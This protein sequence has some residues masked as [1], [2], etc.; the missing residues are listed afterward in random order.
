MILAGD[1]GGTSTRLALFERRA[2][3]LQILAE[4]TYPSQQYPG[5]E[6]IAR[7]FTAEHQARVTKACF[8]IPG[9]VRNGRV[10]TPN[11][12][13][14]VDARV[15]SGMLKTGAVRLINDLE[16]NAHGIAELKPADLVTLNPGAADAQGNTAVISVGTGLFLLA[17]L[18]SR[19]QKATLDNLQPDESYIYTMEINQTRN[20]TVGDET[21]SL[22][23]DMFEA[24][25]VRISDKQKSGDMDLILTHKRIKIDQ[26]FA[27]QVI[28]YDSDNPPN[29][30]DPSM[31]SL[32]VMPGTV[33]TARLTPKGQVAKLDGVDPPFP[34]IDEGIG[35]QRY[36]LKDRPFIIGRQLAH[37]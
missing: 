12:P 30:L 21:Q 14:V 37:D 10:T 13:W 23:Q 27:N 4:H 24:W 19:R 8:G 25:K 11:L 36:P 29:V 22:K 18:V 16:A 2:G 17:G 9:P 26:N 5:L 32:A 7:I 15:L 33:L 34:I 28:E 3:E 1:I 31:R 35:V 20:Q 6:E